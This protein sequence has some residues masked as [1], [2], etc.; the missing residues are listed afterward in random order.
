MS[1]MQRMSSS[2]SGRRCTG[3]LG[4]FTLSQLQKPFT[5]KCSR[6]PQSPATPRCPPPPFCPPLFPPSLPSPPPPTVAGILLFEIRCRLLAPCRDTMDSH[7]P[8]ASM[9][10]K[11]PAGIPWMYRDRAAIVPKTKPATTDRVIVSSTNVLP[12]KRLIKS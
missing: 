12:I 9:S 5:L 6:V 7:P 1:G 4:N 10:C 11:C 2:K 3:W 8:G